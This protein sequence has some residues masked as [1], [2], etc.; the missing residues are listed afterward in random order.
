MTDQTQA[1]PDIVQAGTVADLSDES[2]VQR[3]VT[4]ARDKHA[5]KG[6]PHPRWAGVSSTFGLGSTYSAQ[7]CR[8]FG[9]DPNEMIKR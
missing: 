4:S 1:T 5:R 8:R 3:A 6:Q 7:L 2:L 9:F